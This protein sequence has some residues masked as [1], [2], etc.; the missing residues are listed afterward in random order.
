M[1]KDQTQKTSKYRA[2]L[3]DMDG[4][5][6]N[7]MPYHFHAWKSVF[8]K[9]NIFVDQFEI[10]KREGE[11]GLKT[12]TDI[13]AKHK[14]F[15]P[16]KGKEQLLIQKEELFKKIVTPIIF[17]GVERLIQEIK[18]RGYLLGLV[19]GTSKN[20]METILP[21]H[22][23][24]LFNTIVTGD[25]VTRGKPAPDPYLKALDLLHL[26]S[27]EAIVIENAPYGIQSAKEANI[28]CI[29]L[30]TSLSKDYLKKADY[31]CNSIEEV[32]RLL[33]YSIL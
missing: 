21:D 19:T 15:L 17:P 14:T 27:S 28:I 23:K 29:A 9:K 22:L 12:L 30:T 13:L 18:E 4:V 6:L 2:V 10:Y 26:F 20:E 25:A 16:Q 8:D 33:F 3:F 32:G 5:I 31:I 1:Q 11:P 24:R 7:T